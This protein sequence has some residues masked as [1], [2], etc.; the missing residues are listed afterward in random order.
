VLQALKE[1]AEHTANGGAA[2]RQLF[3]DDAAQGFAFIDLCRQC[4]DVILMN[5]P[6]GKG[7]KN[8]DGY[9][10]S[11]YPDNWK[12]LYAAF[13]ERDLSLL[14]EEGFIGAI[15]SSLFLYTKQLRDFR[16]DLVTK[17][18]LTFL[19]ELGSSVLDSATVDTALSILCKR[20]QSLT[21]FIDLT[22]YEE[23]D[24]VL[25]EAVDGGS[26]AFSIQILDRFKNIYNWPLCYHVSDEKI[27]LWNTQSRLEPDLAT[28]VAG[29]HTFD[30]ERFLRLRYEVPANTIGQ[31]WF[32][33]EKGGEYQPFY[34]PSRLVFKWECN[35]AEA[36]EHQKYHY[37]TDA[38]T[39]QS[40]S[41]WFQ[42]GLTYPRVSSVGFGPRVLPRGFIFS[43]KGMCIFP[44]SPDDA[45]PLLAVLSCSWA[46]DLLNAFGRH[47]AYEN[48]AVANLPLSQAM[49]DRGRSTLHDLGSRGV[50]VILK[51]EQTIEATP[52]FV[53]P[54]FGLISKS[55][56]NAGRDA[57]KLLFE[58]M[59]NVV[60]ELLFGN[61]QPALVSERRSSLIDTFMP[62][63]EVHSK[64]SAS[65]C[66][67]YLIGCAFGRW[68][69]RIALDPTLAPKLQDP[70][71]PLPV[72][73]PGMLVG[74]D[75]L[76]ATPGHI[77]SEEWL[78]ARP[79]AITLPPEGAV[80]QPTIADSEYPLHIAWDGILV[81]DP[82]LDDRAEHPHPSDIVRRVRKVLVVLWGERAEAIEAEACE[83]L[84]VASLRDY[85]RRPSGFF[86]DHLKCYSKSRRQAPIYWPLSTASGRY[87]VWLYYH[88]L[89]QDTLYTVV[90][91]YVTPK[92]DEVQKRIDLLAGRSDLAGLG[93]PARSAAE[94][95]DQLNDLKGFQSE[96]ANFR[97]ELL[98][99]AALPYKPDLND[100]VIINAAPLH[101]L[102]RLRRW[103]TDTA[104]VWKKLEAGEYDWAH[105]AYTLWPE[106]VKQVCETDRSIAI[107]HGLEH[108]CKVEVKQAKR[109][110]RKKAESETET[111]GIGSED[112]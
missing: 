68:D 21:Y 47:R 83:I 65:D 29:N 64:D 42:S 59:D 66:L 26:C 3:A 58:R 69:I 2:R 88:R 103:A 92:L 93:R 18:I 8:A 19:V 91:Q 98:R 34:A 7:A 104:A 24:N 78:R 96:L 50:Q 12:D 39:I 4:Y 108:L 52:V 76:P 32:G 111:M 72:C 23:K 27:A 62:P 77:V 31:K 49:I 43:E 20:P 61:A 82:G 94:L 87:T 95:R 44:K 28:V 13:F 30:D 9:I 57:L 80:R 70:F 1:Y 14:D 100:G 74:L 16:R 37:G 105:L 75:G 89:T 45:L 6:F 11:S 15:T 90:N 22:D 109:K 85:L 101:S 99:V 25:L 53:R 67:S 63:V 36:R 71:D 40:I 33:Y 10:R 48:S 106:R 46:E 35:G 79:N 112:E 17:K 86:A 54:D 56:D 97:A 84:G 110:G 107:A 41:W 73:P 38:Q 60:G 55:P 51:L 81:D 102:F 5:P